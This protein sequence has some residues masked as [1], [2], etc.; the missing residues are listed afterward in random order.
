MLDEMQK[1]A[2]KAAKTLIQGQFNTIALL[3]DLDKVSL[4]WQNHI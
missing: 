2:K 4:L 1:S 3:A